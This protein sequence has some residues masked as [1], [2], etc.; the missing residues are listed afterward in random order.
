MD[1]KSIIRLSLPPARLIIINSRMPKH[2]I[3]QS[4]Q[5]L[6]IKAQSYTCLVL[7]TI[8]ICVNKLEDGYAI[9]IIRYHL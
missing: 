8:C 4:L 1:Q 5:R 6:I 2:F 3:S 7:I 9:S